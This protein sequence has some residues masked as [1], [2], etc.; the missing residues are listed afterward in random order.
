MLE[1][2][3]D[4]GVVKIINVGAKHL[5]DKF[6]NLLKILISKCFALPRRKIVDTGYLR[7]RAKHSDCYILVVFHELSPECFAPTGKGNQIL[8]F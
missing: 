1:V 2:V 6:C 4:G 7:G 8:I 5:G 3:G